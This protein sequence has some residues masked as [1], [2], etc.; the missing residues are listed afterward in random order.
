[1][2]GG[3]PV[4]RLYCN[5]EGSHVL[6]CAHFPEFSGSNADE[7]FT[8]QQ[9]FDRA[10]EKMLR[11]AS[12]EPTTLTLVGEQQGYPVG[13]HLFDATVPRTGR[14]SFAFQEA[15]PP[16]IVLGLD[17]SSEKFWSEIDEDEDLLALGPISPLTSVPA[18]VLTATGWPRQNDLDSP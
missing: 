6:C 1:M 8:T 13:D 7:E 2:A 18:V 9:S 10:V 14:V 17:V 4:F 5:S 12:F 15:G 11:E 16:W 3:F